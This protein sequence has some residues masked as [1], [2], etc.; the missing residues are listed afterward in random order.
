VSEGVLIVSA[1]RDD[2]LRE[3]LA[4][5]VSDTESEATYRGSS[6]PFL[7]GRGARGRR[8]CALRRP[9]GV[10]GGDREALPGGLLATLPGPLLQE[11]AW[12][13]RPRQ[14]QGSGR[15]LTSDL[16]RYE[17]GASPPDRF[18]C[19]REV[20]REGLYAKV[21]EHIEE[22]VEECLS[23]LAF[24]ESQRRRIRTTN[25]Q[26][27]LNQEIKRCTRVVRIFPNGGSRACAQGYGFGARAL[28]GMADRE[29]L[30][31]YGR[32]RG[33]TPRQERPAEGVML[34]K[35]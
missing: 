23:C 5:E 7:K 26:E 11:P 34:M 19:G 30:P 20:A 32:P 28:G 18:E 31:G 17:Q 2:G 12:D 9:R 16:R 35:R 3:I 6:I 21:A 15:G 14:A 13:G 4:V 27:R 8:A 29:A 1:L 10:E 24:P 33:P 25:G 22:Y